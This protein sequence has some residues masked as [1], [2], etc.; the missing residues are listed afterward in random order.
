MSSFKPKINE[1]GAKKDARLSGYITTDPYVI[2]ACN[3]RKSLPQQTQQH[4]SQLKVS[5]K[6]NKQG[7]KTYLKRMLEA[8]EKLANVRDWASETFHS[9]V[10]D[11]NE[12][13]NNFATLMQK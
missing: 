7:V 13:V 6:F 8:R 2:F 11:R 5:Q 3:P 12:I 1:T 10:D 9:S 4:P